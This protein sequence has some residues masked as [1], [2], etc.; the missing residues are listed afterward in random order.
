VYKDIKVELNMYSE[1]G[2]IN[3]LNIYKGYKK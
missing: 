3:G 1:E 2:E